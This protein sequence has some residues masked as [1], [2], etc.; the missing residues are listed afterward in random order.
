MHRAAASCPPS[1]RQPPRR[2]L[3]PAVVVPGAGRAGRFEARA[4]D[5]TVL[6]ATGRVTLARPARDLSASAHA[7]VSLRWLGAGE[8]RPAGA[9]RLPGVVNDVRGRNRRRWRMGVPTYEA[10]LY[11]GLYRGVDARLAPAAAGAGLGAMATYR[12]AAGGRPRGVR[13]RHGRGNSVAR[14]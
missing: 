6:F 5:G 13:L 2:R 14:V 1:A 8:V 10:V 4:A 11:R 7:R 9:Q 12:L 3:L